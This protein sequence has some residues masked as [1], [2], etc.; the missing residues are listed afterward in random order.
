MTR[1]IKDTLRSLLCHISID[2]NSDLS[3]TIFLAGT[4]RSG[5]TW[6][7]NIINYK[8]EYRYMFEPFNPL[9]VPICNNFKYR[10]YL[11]PG[12]QNSK[13][14]DPSKAILSGKVRNRWIDRYN[15][16]IFSTKR[17]IKD[18]R[19]NLLLKWLSVNFPYIKIVLLLRHPCAIANSKLILHWGTHLDEF[20]SQEELIEDFLN[21]F[22]PEIQKAQTTFEKHIFLWCIEN[23]IPLMQFTEGN[24]HLT[25]YEYFCLEPNAEIKR[26]FNF[27]NKDFHES[28]L[29]NLKKPSQVS[30]QGSAILTGKDLINS[31]KKN[32]SRAQ[33]KRA[34]EILEYFG[35]NKIYSEDSLPDIEK[36]YSFV[37]GRV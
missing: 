9:E 5:T 33:I 29:T 21:P 27:L 14:I 25:F 13:Y 11:R 2:C 10:Q 16:K 26:L 4:G 31:W 34:V 32:I 20:L 6:V 22:L 15:N 3:K 36:A 17:L 23:Y 35:L 28:I 30:R 24:I 18:I 19:A 12:N 1:G 8:N 7:S 37:C